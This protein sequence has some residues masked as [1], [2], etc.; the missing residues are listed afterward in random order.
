MPHRPALR[1]ESTM[2]RQMRAARFFWKMPR[3][4]TSQVKCA[5]PS[6]SN[7]RR[8]FLSLTCSPGRLVGPYLAPGEEGCQGQTGP[9][10][11]VS[12][13]AVA[14]GVGRHLHPVAAD[15]H[16]APAAAAGARGVA[17]VEDAARVRALP[18]GRGP[19]LRGQVRRGPRDPGHGPERL[20]PGPGEGQAPPP[21]LPGP[22]AWPRTPSPPPAVPR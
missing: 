21:P 13:A 14:P 10:L 5:I 15:R 3:Y 22:P 16:R 12:A 9:G 1:A 4:T 2:P 18:D 19:A 6:S 8:C 7:E 11:G 17:E 20:A